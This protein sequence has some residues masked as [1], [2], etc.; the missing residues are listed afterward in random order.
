MDKRYYHNKVGYNDNGDAFRHSYWSALMARRIGTELAYRFGLA[1][2]NLDRGYNWAKLNDDVKMDVSNN[3]Y[4]RKKG[5]ALMGY[6]D[7]TVA[8]NLEGSVTKGWLKRLSNP[9]IRTGYW[10]KTSGYG[11]R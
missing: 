10:I 6:R 7:I 11:R 8:N 2:E 4:G 3:F 5:V 1:H 9:S